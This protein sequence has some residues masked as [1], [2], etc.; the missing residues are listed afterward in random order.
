MDFY[1]KSG[2]IDLYE[3][4]NF[5]VT[6][7]TQV[8]HSSVFNED[9]DIVSTITITDTQT[10]KEI[11]NRN[12][13]NN[14]VK[15]TI[16]D[17]CI[18]NVLFYFSRNVL[19]SYSIN[20]TINDVL[21]QNNG[22]IFCHRMDQIKDKEKQELENKKRIAEREAIENENKKLIQEYCNKKNLYCKFIYSDLYVFKI[23]KDI[24]KITDLLNSADSDKMDSYVDYATKYP[25]NELT[26]IYIGSDFDTMLSDLKSIKI[27]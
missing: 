22:T 20:K 9:N 10:N 3:S 13:C 23:N 5:K 7:V 8:Y 1:N 14:F 4:Y 27:K 24:E 2:I 16:F 25:N 26:V 21:V 11:F 18:D 19:D 15:K 12:L 6:G 17:K